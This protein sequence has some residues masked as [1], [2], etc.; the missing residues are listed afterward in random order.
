MNPEAVLHVLAA[1]EGAGLRGRVDGGWGVDALLER[2]TRAHDD[3]DLVVEH[4]ECDQVIDVLLR[5]GFRVELDEPGHVVL[6]HAELGRVDLHPVT[7]DGFG[8]AVQV[9]PGDSPVVYTG[10]GFVA[11]SIDGCAVPCRSAEVQLRRMAF[12]RNAKHR[13]DVAALCDSFGIE[14]PPGWLEV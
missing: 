5:G 12:E 4:E 11:G 1:L 3:L 10:E 14:V 2:V 13:R 8:N 7:F 9:Q 6:E